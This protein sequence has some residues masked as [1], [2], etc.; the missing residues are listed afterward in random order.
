ME[1]SLV[2]GAVGGV[3][4]VLL[5]VWCCWLLSDSDRLQ[6]GFRAAGMTVA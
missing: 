3:L 2:G 1:L 6:V 5:V 4:V